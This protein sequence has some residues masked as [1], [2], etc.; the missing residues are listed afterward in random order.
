MA[1]LEIKAKQSWIQRQRPMC[2]LILSL[3]PALNGDVMSGC[4][5]YLATAGE[6]EPCMLWMAHGENGSICFGGVSTQWLHPW[7]TMPCAWF[8]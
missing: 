7:S 2:A 1:I 8:P 6:E 4:G 5:G 3:R